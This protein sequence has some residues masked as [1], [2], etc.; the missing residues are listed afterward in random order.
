MKD[1]FIA[2]RDSFQ[3]EDGYMVA[4]IHDGREVVKQFIPES[5]YDFFCKAIG[6]IPEIK[7]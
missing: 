3:G 7:E 2:E 4:Q 5:S 6:V 1:K